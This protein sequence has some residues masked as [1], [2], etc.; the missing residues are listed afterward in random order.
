MASETIHDFYKFIYCDEVDGGVSG[1][2]Y[3]V[4]V[5][6]E[7][8]KEA[9]LKIANSNFDNEDKHDYREFLQKLAKYCVENEQEGVIIHFG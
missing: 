3:Y 7:T 9:I 5:K 2:G 1:R 4:I 8:I 6:L